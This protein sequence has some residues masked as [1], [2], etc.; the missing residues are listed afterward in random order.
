[1]YCL[2]RIAKHERKLLMNYTYRPFERVFLSS[3]VSFWILFS[4]IV[5]ALVGEHDVCMRAVSECVCVREYYVNLLF[6][7]FWPCKFIRFENR[8]H[9]AHLFHHRIIEYSTHKSFC[10]FLTNSYDIHNKIEIESR[11]QWEA[12]A[13]MVPTRQRQQYSF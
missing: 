2:K 6:Y 4:W 1:M 9:T 13:T 12:T 5:A 10:E 7:R 3:C 11:Q 8:A